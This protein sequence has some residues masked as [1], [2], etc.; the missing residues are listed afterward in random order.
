MV[1]LVPPLRAVDEDARSPRV[2]ARPSQ[3]GSPPHDREPSI[4]LAVAKVSVMSGTEAVIPPAWYPDSEVPGGERWWD[5]AAWTDYRRSPEDIAVAAAA[6]AAPAYVAPVVAETPAYT[7]P[8]YTTPA[9]AAPGYAAPGYAAPAAGY[10][11][12]QAPIVDPAT[13]QVPLWA[14]LYGASFGQSWKRFWRKYA[15]FSGRASR[16]EFWFA[17]LAIMILVFGSYMVLM[18]LS[19]TASVLVSAGSDNGGAVALGIASAV[20]GLLLSLG[21]LAMIVPL[22]AV[23]VRR[24]HD[25][26]YPGT[27]Y[28]FGFIPFVGGILLLVYLASESK[29]QGAMYDRPTA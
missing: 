18:V 7:A 4:A 13:G 9:Y 20:V 24:L 29:P 8:A 22:I 3:L 23:S 28:F 25:A 26:G 21:Y 15:D 14:P 27:Y 2:A 1:E 17:Y 19:I 5:G 16:S 12:A 6:D 10:G 11:F